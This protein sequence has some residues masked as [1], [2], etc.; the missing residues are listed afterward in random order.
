MPGE[1]GVSGIQGIPGVNG[2]N[3]IQGIP[4]VNGTKGE[5]WLYKDGV[6]NITASMTNV[7]DIHASGEIM[8]DENVNIQ[9]SF[10]TSHNH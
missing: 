3:G 4:G 5:W 1:Q 9:G 8:G 6:L 7:V 2:T 10:F